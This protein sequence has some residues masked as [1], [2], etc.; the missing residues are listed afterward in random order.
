MRTILVKRIVCGQTWYEATNEKTILSESLTGNSRKGIRR[1]DPEAV[2]QRNLENN[3][4][5]NNGSLQSHRR[6][7]TVG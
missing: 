4:R 5:L 2:R 1:D 3:R 6:L 7:P